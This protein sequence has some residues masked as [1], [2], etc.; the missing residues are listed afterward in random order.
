VK[1]K[2][3]YNGE[4][5]MADSIIEVELRDGSRLV[6]RDDGMRHTNALRISASGS[7]KRGWKSEGLAIVPD[8]AN[9]MIVYCTPLGNPAAREDGA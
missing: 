8:S 5:V 1:V 7:S 2:R 3:L 9:S 4:T 6:L